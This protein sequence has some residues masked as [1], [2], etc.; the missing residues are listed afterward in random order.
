[1]KQLWHTVVPMIK[2]WSVL[3]PKLMIGF[4]DVMGTPEKRVVGL[5][6]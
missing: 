5:G 1:M 4:N 3:L 2:C 6:F